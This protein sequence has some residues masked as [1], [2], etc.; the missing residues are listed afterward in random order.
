MDATDSR[1][2]EAVRE[3]WGQAVRTETQTASWLPN[4]HPTSA[5]KN[6]KAL[7]LAT[8]PTFKG[9]GKC[10]CCHNEKLVK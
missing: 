6:L 3:R 2:A 5:R 1:Q 7:T 10:F 4:V 9:A 8:P